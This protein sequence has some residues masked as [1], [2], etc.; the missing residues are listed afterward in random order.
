MLKKCIIFTNQIKQ[1]YFVI[2]WLDAGKSMSYKGYG[3]AVVLKE[4]KGHL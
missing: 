3:S 2:D 4:G 1:I